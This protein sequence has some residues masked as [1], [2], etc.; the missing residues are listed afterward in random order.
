M[1]NASRSSR[2]LVAACLVAVTWLSATP[3][4]AAAL[5]P[6]RPLPGYRPD[7]VTETDSLPWTDCLWASGAML[8][9]KW[10]NGEV[11][12]TRQQLRS[13]SRDHRG[14]STL[15]DLQAAYAKLGFRLAY[16][17]DGGERISWSQLLRRLEAGAGAVM[18]GNDSALP[19]RYGRWDPE[20]WKQTD[21]EK[22]NHAVYIERY[23][24]WRGRVWLMDPLARGDWRGEWISVRALRKFAWTSGGALSVAITPTARPAPF[25]GVKVAPPAVSVTATAVEARWTVRSPR[26][27]SFPGADLTAAFTP[28]IDPLTAAAMLAAMPPEVPAVPADP[29]GPAGRVGPVGPVDPGDA[30]P[31]GTLAPN[32]ATGTTDSLAASATLPTAPGAYLAALTVT[33]RRFGRAVAR[34]GDIPVFVPGPRRATIRLGVLGTDVEP[35]SSLSLSMSV[36]N[37]G[38]LTWAET[39]RPAGMPEEV[40]WARNTRILARWI[41][42]DVQV[43][44]ASVPVGASEG[45]L[46]ATA[47]AGPVPGAATILGAAL[48]MP[49]PIP[50]QPVPLAPGRQVQVRTDLTIPT[51]PGLWALVVDLADDTEGSFA[52]HGSAPAVALFR[53]GTVPKVPPLD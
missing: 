47:I 50:L 28:A 15:A 14:G 37:T 7:F 11:K 34:S 13:L 21:P 32:T 42:L 4:P 24:R 5:E 3:A 53:V 39:G 27:W 29:A 19:R 30:P 35:G 23:D 36:A 33:D 12:V 44:T 25:S 18:L 10:T 8:L 43:E 41:P 1:P 45:A 31:D 40:A 6:P 52:A 26:G 20:F 48:S 38:D 16:S 49:D 17:P 9:D 2:A 46:G 22:D 51:A